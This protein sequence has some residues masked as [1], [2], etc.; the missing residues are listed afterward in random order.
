[1]TRAFLISQ[2][3]DNS[4]TDIRALW[5]MID[6][7]PTYQRQSDLWERDKRQLFIDSLINGYD[8]PK[9]YFHDLNWNDQGPNKRYAIIDGKQRL[10]A[11]NAFINGDFP[12]SGDFED[13]EHE[14]TTRG[15]AA[16]GARYAQL[17]SA[18]P[19]LKARF[20]KARLPIVL[21]QTRGTTA[22]DLEVIEEMFSRLNEAVPLNA[23]EKRNARGGPLPRQIRRLARD[24]FFLSRLGFPNYRYRHLDLATKF[25]FIEFKDGLSDLKKRDLDGFVED[26]KNRGRVEESERVYKASTQ[27]LRQMSAV[28]VESDYLLLSVG[29]VTIYYFLFRRAMADGWEQEISRD[30]LLQFDSER[31]TNRARVKEAQEAAL[32]GKQISPTLHIDPILSQFERYVQSPN[33]AKALTRRFEVL[34]RFVRER[35]AQGTR[36]R[37]RAHSQPE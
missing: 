10:E 35:A 21:I 7:Q 27:V 13:V 15:G 26:F 16:A 4:V 12:L 30:V 29:M 24:R 11:I 25:L 2:L 9:L 20:D 36:R 28:F 32:E 6:L 19:D 1:M 34:R 14:G 37:L 17:A 8:I 23:P 33:D 31:A 22:Q 5:P 3:R 18:H